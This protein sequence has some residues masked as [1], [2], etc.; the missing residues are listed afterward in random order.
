[1]TNLDLKL[2][3]ARYAEHIVTLRLSQ[4]RARVSELK[5]E[6]SESW[7]DADHIQSCENEIK[8]E[9]QFIVYDE[10]NLNSLAAEIEQ[11][12]K[13]LAFRDLGLTFAEF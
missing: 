6:I 9:Q 13:D 7:D 5:V 12:Q 4:R 11:Y 2:R 10:N 8:Q 3:Q 1:M